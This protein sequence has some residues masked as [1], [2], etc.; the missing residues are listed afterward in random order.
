MERDN[1][2]LGRMN[3]SALGTI[4]QMTAKI[5]S[6]PDLESAL[7]MGAFPKQFTF[8][9]QYLPT[10]E[11][12]RELLLSSRSHLTLEHMCFKIIGGA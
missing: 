12:F 10:L 4:K 9:H 6:V 3:S 7:Q 5:C 2:V 8:S 1:S 11:E